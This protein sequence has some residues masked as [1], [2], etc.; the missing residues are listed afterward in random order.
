[1]IVERSDVE[2]TG[3]GDFASV[4]FAIVARACGLIICCCRPISPGRKT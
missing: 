2:N 4:K 3:P 1:V